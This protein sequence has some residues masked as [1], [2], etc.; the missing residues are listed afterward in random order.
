MRKLTMWRKISQ[1][2]RGLN[3]MK[4]AFAVKKDL[5]NGKWINHEYSDVEI[6]IL[7]WLRSQTKEV[8][9][10]ILPSLSNGFAFPD[11]KKEDYVKKYVLKVK[12]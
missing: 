5:V 10:E 7:L 4:F 3:K 12:K 2:S 11:I 6:E 9:S 8:I 1:T